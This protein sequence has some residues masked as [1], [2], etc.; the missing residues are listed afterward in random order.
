MVSEEAR[1]DEQPSMSMHSYKAAAPEPG[2][3]MIKI[4]HDSHMHTPHGGLQNGH[5]HHDEGDRIS[6]RP[7]G[8][9]PSPDKVEI[10]FNSIRKPLYKQPVVE[11]LQKI[12]NSVYHIL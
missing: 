6:T 2:P 1:E 11:F 7:Q 5:L 3:H 4:E 12:R 8:L 9:S 10:F